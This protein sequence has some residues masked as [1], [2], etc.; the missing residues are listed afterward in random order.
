MFNLVLQLFIEF[1]DYNKQSAFDF[2]LFC[3]VLDGFFYL[4]KFLSSGEFYSL[5]MY[6][7][8]FLKTDI[9]IVLVL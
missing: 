3:L 4:K 7:S 2:N 5:S 9:I 8:K 6:G 1:F